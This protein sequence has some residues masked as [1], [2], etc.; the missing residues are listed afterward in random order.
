VVGVMETAAEAYAVALAGEAPNCRR[1]A[2]RQRL[3][4]AITDARPATAAAPAAADRE[5]QRP[6]APA[7]LTAFLR[8]RSTGW[9]VAT[10]ALVALIW[11]VSPRPPA[12]RPAPG[13]DHAQTIQGMPALIAGRL[14]PA[15]A[16]AV[17]EHMRRCRHC[18]EIY[19]AQWRAAQPK[20]RRTSQ[21][22]PPVSGQVP[23]FVAW[24]GRP[25]SR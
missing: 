21:G 17:W 24:N 6:R 22:I 20:P 15:K 4:A 1:E 14:E 2:V 8:S 19:E 23:L 7:W 18:F 11:S 25:E 16:G 12:E 5:A 9:A 13:L 10:A 3:H